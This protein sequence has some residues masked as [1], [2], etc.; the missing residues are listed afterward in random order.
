MEPWR[1]IVCGLDFSPA[2]AAAVRRAA[3]LAHELH[4]AL[5]VVHAAYPEQHAGRDIAPGKIF[6]GEIE[7]AQAR[8]ERC[9]AEAEESSGMPVRAYFVRGRPAQMLAEVVREVGGE[10]L[11]LG[12][13]GHG[14]VGEALGSV[15]GAL[16]RSPPCALL[17]VRQQDST[18]SATG[19]AA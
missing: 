1:T 14:R 5:H 17:L 19:G 13:H 7:S 10:L 16:A 15:A 12:V 9:R 4:A 18:E 3:W 6:E 8:L 11:V 2:S